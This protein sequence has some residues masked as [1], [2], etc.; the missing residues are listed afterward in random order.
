MDL[1]KMIDDDIDRRTQLNN[2]D[3][4]TTAKT[5]GGVSRKSAASI[6]INK[7]NVT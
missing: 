1:E 7:G 5:Y 2:Q 3:R 6:G 4:K